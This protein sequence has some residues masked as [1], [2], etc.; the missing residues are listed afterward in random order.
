MSNDFEGEAK[1]FALVVPVPTILKE[2]DIKV[3]QGTPK[4]FQHKADSGNTMTKEFCGDCG[5][6]IFGQGSGSTGVKHVKAG[7]LDDASFVKP[8]I[9][10]F[11][12]RKLPFTRLSD[13]TEHY[14]TMRPQ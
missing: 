3:L 4:Q 11:T 6:Q 9:E 2:E 12:S 10:V 14:E 7:T 5:S 1:D 8:Q 13:E